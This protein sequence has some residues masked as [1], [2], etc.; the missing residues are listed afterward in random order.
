MPEH[1]K[2]AALSLFSVFGRWGWEEKIHHEKY[3]HMGHIFHDGVKESCRRQEPHLYGCDSHHWQ[4]GRW[5]VTSRISKTCPMGH[6]MLWVEGEG[7][8]TRNATQSHVSCVWL[9]E[10]RAE[11]RCRRREMRL[12]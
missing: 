4:G 5:A 12:I 1:P 7:A 2:R 10:E 6:S 9:V 8:D 11:D 3:G